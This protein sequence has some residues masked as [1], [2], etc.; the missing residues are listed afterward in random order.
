MKAFGIQ[1][2]KLTGLAA[3]L[4]EWGKRV[5]VGAG[6]FTA[7]WRTEDLQWCKTLHVRTNRYSGFEIIFSKPL[8]AYTWSTSVPWS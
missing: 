5:L 1:V 8:S 6:R 7:R 2:E 3:G 4:V